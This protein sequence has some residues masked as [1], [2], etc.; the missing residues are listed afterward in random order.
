MK[1]TTGNEK[2]VTSP[3]ND[4]EIQETIKRSQNKGIPGSR[5]KGESL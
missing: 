4:H 3:N 1:R 2:E 5:K